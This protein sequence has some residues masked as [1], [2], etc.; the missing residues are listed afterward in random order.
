M[1]FFYMWKYFFKLVPFFLILNCRYK[2]NPLTGR[3]QAKATIDQFTK[4]LL[5]VNLFRIASKHTRNIPTAN[6]PI[7]RAGRMESLKDRTQRITSR[8][9][10]PIAKIIG[11][12]RLKNQEKAGMNLSNSHMK[13]K[14]T[15]IS[16]EINRYGLF[17]R[18]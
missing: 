15:I 11:K 13:R 3:M 16:I 8:K 14:K 10:I 17:L 12:A 6:V 5:L 4:I 18:W 9:R 7:E 1:R 2:N